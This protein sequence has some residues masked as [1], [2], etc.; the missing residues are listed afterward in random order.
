[1]KDISSLNPFVSTSELCKME[2]P[3]FK[4]SPA[5]SAFIWQV[6]KLWFGFQSFIHE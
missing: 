6:K 5:A 4:E 2:E 1:M 3:L